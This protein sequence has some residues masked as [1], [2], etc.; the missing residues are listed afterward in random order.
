MSKK[1]YTFEIINN[2]KKVYN[3]KDLV[4][5]SN[6]QMI[7]VMLEKDERL[8]FVY[9]TLKQNMKN[10]NVIKRIGGEFLFPAETIRLYPMFD[11]GYGFPFLQDKKHIGYIIKGEVYK[12]KSNMIKF[13]DEFEGV[14]KLY[15]KE[16][17]QVEFKCNVMEASCYFIADE[18]T[19][20]ELKKVKFFREW[21]E[22]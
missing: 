10:H 13:L 5:Y 7:E 8:F 1:F 18:L 4:D 22:I 21:I 2:T 17:I 16:L 11:L 9:G 14:P 12:F 15:K 3:Y 6:D 19:E 20:D